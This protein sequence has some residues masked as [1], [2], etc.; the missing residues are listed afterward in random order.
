MNTIEN[1]EFQSNDFELTCNHSHHR[2]FSKFRHITLTIPAEEQ[3]NF[4]DVYHVQ[5]QYLPQALRLTN[6]FQSA[7]NPDDLKFDFETALAIAK[8]IPNSG[9][10][11]TM[12]QNVVQEHLQISVMIDQIKE[13]VKTILGLSISSVSFWSAVAGAITNTFTNLNTQQD[14]AWILWEREESSNTSY[15]YNILFSIQNEETGGVMAV[16]PI[17]FEISVNVN[18]ESVLFFTIRDSARYEVRIK[19]ITL[20]QALD[21]IN[22]HLRHCSDIFDM[23]KD[24]PYIEEINTVKNK[25]LIDHIIHKP[26][27]SNGLVLPDSCE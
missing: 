6:A 9:I 16:L 23:H 24:N 22:R 15:Y 7:I 26:V 11:N 4:S 10:I 17:S 12:N 13:L 19:A 21:P 14:A 2:S 5:P 27:R 1:T 8:E 3:Y 20:A 18:K 25:R